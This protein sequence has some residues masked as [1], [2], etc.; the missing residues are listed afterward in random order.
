MFETSLGCVMRSWYPNLGYS[1]KISVCHHLV[2]TLQF[3]SLNS[4]WTEYLTETQMCAPRTIANLCHE[5]DSRVIFELTFRLMCLE[6]YIPDLLAFYIMLS[7]MVVHYQ[8]VL[9]L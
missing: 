2:C 4:R 6:G 7:T 8:E 9:L 5:E 3:A 1:T